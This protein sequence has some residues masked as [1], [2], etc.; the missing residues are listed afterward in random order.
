MQV[1]IK[2]GEITVEAEL[3]RDAVEVLN[4]LAARVLDIYATKP[5]ALTEHVAE[6]REKAKTVHLRSVTGPEVD[7]PTAPRAVPVAVEPAPA[8]ETVA[9]P[10]VPPAVPGARDVSE[11]LADE[12]DATYEHRE[13]P[14]PTLL[15]EV[16]RVPE[17]GVVADAAKPGNG[18]SSSVDAEAIVALQGATSLRPIFNYFL[19]RQ[20]TDAEGLFAAC[21]RI[22]EQIP[23]L[24]TMVNFEKRV[25]TALAVILEKETPQAF[26]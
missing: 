26:S 7:R 18:P 5:E 13:D 22:K 14:E 17:P 2:P 16:P 20:I 8:N 4:S 23:Y 11:I 19:D 25:R 6:K 1:T 24:A 12:S 15:A 3:A 21:V 9:L 10:I